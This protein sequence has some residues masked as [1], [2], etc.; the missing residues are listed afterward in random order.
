[1]NEKFARAGASEYIRADVADTG[2]GIDEGTLKRIFEPFFTTKEAGKG[3]GLGLSTVYSIVEG[4]QGFVDVESELGRGTVFHVYLPASIRGVTR[5]E[6]SRHPEAE[7]RGKGETVLLIEDEQILRDLAATA[8]SE[9][10]Y[11]V[12][13]ACDGEVGL[14]TFAGNPGGIALI[15]TDLGLPKLGGEELVEQLLRVNP[16]AKILM[17]SGYVEPDMKSRLLRLG[18]KGFI[19]K[20]YSPIEMLKKVRLSIDTPSA[21]LESG[22]AKL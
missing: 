16:E 15:L 6:P 5:T 4:H 20:P 3:T 2:T 22:E 14:E 17:V 1:V 9:A 11:H 21:G 10:G 7:F 18:A 8:L 12:L 19:Q 13:T